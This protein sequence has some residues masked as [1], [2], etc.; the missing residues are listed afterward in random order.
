MP[1]IRGRVLVVFVLSL[2]GEAI[3]QDETTWIRYPD[4]PKFKGEAQHPDGII[5]KTNEPGAYGI[6]RSVLQKL[7]Q[8]IAETRL[9]GR[10]EMETVLG[11]SVP[12]SQVAER[13]KH[14]RW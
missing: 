8:Q 4:D 12:Q 11:R 10:Q 9:A 6:G 5:V 7:N 3:L 1:S 2:A 13:M 14:Q